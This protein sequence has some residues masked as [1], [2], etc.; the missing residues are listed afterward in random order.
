M[1]SSSACGTMFLD[2]GEDLGVPAARDSYLAFSAFAVCPTPSGAVGL[3]VHTHSNAGSDDSRLPRLV[4]YMSS[5]LYSFASHC[6]CPCSG[7]GSWEFPL[8]ALPLL[9]GLYQSSSIGI[10]TSAL[11]PEAGRG[12]I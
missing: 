4:W 1:D 7:Q 12:S 9:H 8:A 6:P 11:T 10:P 5:G 2:G 3:C